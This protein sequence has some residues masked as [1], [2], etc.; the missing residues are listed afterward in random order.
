M[1][2]WSFENTIGE[3]L[4]NESTRALIAELA[5]EVFDHPMIEVG[6]A[7]TV[8][9]A[10]PFIEGLADEERIEAFRQALELLED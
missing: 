5:P 10:L 1:A 8:N 7:F 2:K 9:Q 4:D 3:L 6:K